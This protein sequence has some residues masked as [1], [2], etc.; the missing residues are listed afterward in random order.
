MILDG[1]ITLN[2]KIVK[3]LGVKASLSID[4]IKVDGKKI[5][6]QES[7]FI[8]L[9][10]PKGYISSMKDPQ[11]RKTVKEL[12]RDISIRIY[13]VGRLDYNSEGLML[14]TNDGEMAHRLMHPSGKVQKRY[15][16]KIKGFLSSKEIAIMEKG[17]LL[18]GLKTL[19][20]QIKKIK[21]NKNSWIEITMIEGKKNQIRR[22]LRMFNHPVLKLNRQ[23]YG[24]L[25]THGLAVGEFR[26]LR[27]NEL[28]RLKKLVSI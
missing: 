15:L 19:P 8:I 7:I 22:M 12:L 4:Q 28:K 11:G 9:N 16:V 3:N 13:P 24:F 10:K 2:G 26:F 25:T 6:I 20:M 14:F 17:F 5:K 23:G 27:E 18:D 1:R 21:I